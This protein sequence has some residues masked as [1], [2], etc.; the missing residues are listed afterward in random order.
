[1]YINRET[2]TYAANKAFH[3]VSLNGSTNENRLGALWGFL[4]KI[5]I[6]KHNRNVRGLAIFDLKI[7]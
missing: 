4:Y 7:S 6:P 2:P 5:L 3:R 1:M